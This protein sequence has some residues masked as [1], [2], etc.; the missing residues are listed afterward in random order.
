MGASD[1]ISPVVPRRRLRIELKRA[2][3]DAGET[4]GEVAA[5]MDWSLSKVIRIEAGTVSIS[6]NDLKAL[7]RYYKIV[8]PARTDELINLGKAARDRTWW[9][10][11][12]EKAPS[13]LLQLIGYESGASAR[14]NF[15]P[16][17]IPGL[18]QTEDYA[19]AVIPALD[20]GVSQERVNTLV[21]VRM[22]RQELVHGANPPQLYFVLDE[23]AIRRLTGGPEVMRGQLHHLMKM[24]ERPN[25]T[26]EVILFSAGIHQGMRG[27]FVVLEF[28][29]PS[30]D[31]VLYVEDTTGG[32]VIRED[33]DEIQSYR[34]IFER[35][36][37]VSLGPKESLGHIGKLADEIH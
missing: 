32:L 35:L 16:L 7:L 21:E 17:L 22:R 15:E 24:A 12:R 8:D 31:D 27:S 33:R 20:E 5:A 26:I 34:E 1:D 25:V 28:P 29:H 9:S 14:R 19:R 30:D 3:L 36:R 37:G 23:A 13:G 11:Y 2:R 18:L 10:D 4:Q 6:T